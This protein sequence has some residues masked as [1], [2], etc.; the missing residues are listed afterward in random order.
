MPSVQACGRSLPLYF[1]EQPKELT[2]FVKHDYNKDLHAGWTWFGMG[3]KRYGSGLPD[4]R[5]DL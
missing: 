2:A 1:S 4:V 3:C 5:C